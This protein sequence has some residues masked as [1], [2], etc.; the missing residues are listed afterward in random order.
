MPK[1]HV[2][3]LTIRNQTQL[4]MTFAGDWFDSGRVADG[5]SWPKTI[6]P[7]GAQTIECY[8][9]DWSTA[10]CSGYAQYSM[11][12]RGEVTIAF[13]NPASG[14]NKFGVGVGGK[15]VWENIDDHG[16]NTFLQEFQLGDARFPAT[17]RCT[18]GDVND[19]SVIINGA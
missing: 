12:E 11:G 9:S 16:Y 17:C 15:S 3:K 19:A 13:S 8:E 6:A 2:V 14:T 18:G 5:W 4:T 7:G 1:S 10:G